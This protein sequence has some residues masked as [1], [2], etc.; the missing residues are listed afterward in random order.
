VI[1]RLAGVAL[2][3]ATAFGF[4]PLLREI[5]RAADQ[6][7]ELSVDP[8]PQGRL[9]VRA[10]LDP[11]D[12]AERTLLSVD[13]APVETAFGPEGRL[14]TTLGPFSAGMHTVC[15]RARYGGL[16]MR[17]VCRAVL[18]GPLEPAA[19][20]ARRSVRIFIAEKMLSELE[21]IAARR[22][23]E[24]VAEK[25]PFVKVRGARVK[26]SL[27][28]KGVRVRGRV[29]L[30]DGSAARASVLVGVRF[31]GARV[32]LQRIGRT[33]VFAG[34]PTVKKLSELGAALGGALGALL[35]DAKGKEIG[36]ALGQT[37]VGVALDAILKWAVERVL[38]REVLPA[39]AEALTLPDAIEIGPEWGAARLRV[40]YA[41][42][43]RFEPGRGIQL[44]FDVDLGGGV[45]PAAG[46]KTQ[47]PLSGPGWLRRP[48]EP[49][50]A[51]C[52]DVVVD[53]SPDVANRLLHG[54]WAQGRLR[55]LAN[56][57]SRLAEWDARLADLV[58]RPVAIDFELPPL[59]QPV[60]QGPE[61]FD[62]AV[63]EVAL[64]LVPRLT[65]GE[66]PQAPGPIDAR[67]MVQ[68]GLDLSFD[69][70]GR[71]ILVQ[72]RLRDVGLACLSEADPSVRRPCF[73]DALR[74]AREEL[75]RPDAAL[76]D[77]LRLSLERLNPLAASKASS[78]E[79]LVMEISR[80]EPSIAGGW[81]RLTMQAR[82]AQARER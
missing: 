36:E 13:R 8:R 40:R 57:P 51:P 26:L 54:L 23:H 64:R 55:A 37:L 58:V 50:P 42:E 25:V 38:D 80:V 75:G 18:V 4:W 63:G 35:G 32:K 19:S 72:G 82:F 45:P 61:A 56:E 71:T 17:E 24:A 41:D 70:T 20:P 2:F 43:P 67:L 10:R 28:K 7:Y 68:L 65:E 14:E 33:E 34:G 29:M 78:H 62:L 12:L 9:A 81:I 11:P 47:G 30:E 66:R 73:D 76:F 3:L 5:G 74:I 79:G 44:A 46:P 31:A 53:V 52:A 21:G 59:V 39:L 27:E 48:G 22:L 6:R 60:A 1:A 69:A 49:P 15:L 16:R 77:L